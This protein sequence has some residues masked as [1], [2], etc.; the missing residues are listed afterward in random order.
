MSAMSG[1]ALVSPLALRIT[2]DAERQIRFG[3]PWLYA[4]GI[5]KQ[6]REGQAGE[7]AVIYDRRN[8]FLALG[9]Y[10]PASPIRVRIL[11]RHRPSP[12]NAAWFRDRLTQALTRRAALLR[13]RTTTAYRLV[14][15]E[16]DHLPGIILDR[17]DHA[18]VL[19]LYTAAWLPHLP[20]LAAAREIVETRS[21][22]LRLGRLAQAAVG[23]AT[24]GMIVKGPAPPQPVAFLE[25]G[26]R[27]QA[28]LLRGQKTG[29]FL[30]QRDN[31]VQVARLARGRTVL[32]AFSYTGAC[33]VY[34]A[35]GGA[36]EI[37]SLDASRQA[38]A[39][40]KT[41]MGMNRDAPAIA[42]ARHHTILGD[43]FKVL[44]KLRQEKRRYG[45]VILDPP[46]LASSQHEVPEALKAYQR[47]AAMGVSLLE[48]KGILVM[49]SCTGHVS[50]E[51]FLTSVHRAARQAG[52]PLK[53]L[54]CTG[55]PVDHP[56]SF[57]EGAYL[58]CLFAE[59]P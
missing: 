54:W 25:H 14:H 39:A 21:L 7:F 26:L 50:T 32:D 43:A 2:P 41:H 6:D 15:G 51:A 12:I 57:R 33:S 19:K 44:P 28:D 13:N 52:R 9:L 4:Q 38:L 22:I 20:M 16:N 30:D 58:K 40:A 29:F 27:F 10:D 17:Y 31:R 56:I 11:Q 24:D 37:T 1:Q 35:R 42:K 55:Q 59:A 3:H 49:S 23:T 45:M 53:E 18:L 34:A 5:T 46:S 47:L 48:R 36:R 8:R